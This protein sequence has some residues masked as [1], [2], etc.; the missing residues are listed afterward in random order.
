VVLDPSAPAVVAVV[1]AA[2]EAVNDTVDNGAPGVPVGEGV[3]EEASDVTV[4]EA[5][6]EELP[7]VTMELCPG[8]SGVGS[9]ITD[10]QEYEIGLIDNE[11]KFSC[12]NYGEERSYM[13]VLNGS[14]RSVE[15]AH[16]P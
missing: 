11:E 7:L 1:V 9:S 6:V 2:V 16:L 14:G 4:V 5:V 8:T 15:S 13:V 3:V 12:V 10:D